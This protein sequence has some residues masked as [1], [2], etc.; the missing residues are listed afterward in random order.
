[1]KNAITNIPRNTI[2][3][4]IKLKR[5]NFAMNNIRMMPNI[6]YL[7]SLEN[8]FLEFNYSRFIPKSALCG[9]PKLTM[10]NLTANRIPSIEDL[11]VLSPCDVFIGRN[12]IVSLPDL[13]DKTLQK[14]YIGGNPFLC[15]HS[16]C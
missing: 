5:F 1:M 10:L 13:F 15:D 6:S 3:G 8:I 7:S 11:P 2:E 4:L 12:Q 14:L 9:L 16:L